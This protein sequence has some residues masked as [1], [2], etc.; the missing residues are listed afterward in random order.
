MFQGGDVTR[1]DGTGGKRMDS[2]KFAGSS[3]ALPHR[4]ERTPDEIFQLR[5]EKPGLL[6]MA[7]AG[8]NTNGSQVRTQFLLSSSYHDLP[9]LPRSLRHVPA[10]RY[11][12]LCPCSPSAFV[13]FLSP[14]FVP[15]RP[16]ADVFQRLITTIIHSHSTA[17]SSF[18]AC[19]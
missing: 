6:S 8:K 17:G 10:R 15:P 5:Q 7:N 11:H 13:A 1:D 18:S 12:L 16:S 4:V 19:S 3:R 9:F 14:S 2:G